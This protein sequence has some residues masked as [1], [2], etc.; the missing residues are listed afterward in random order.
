MSRGAFRQADLARA[1]RAA[2]AAGWPRGSFKVLV[3]DGVIEVLPIGA[4]EDE[5]VALGRRI[6]ALARGSGGGDGHRAPAVRPS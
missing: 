3:R 4:A 2:E 6:D 1:I 5:G